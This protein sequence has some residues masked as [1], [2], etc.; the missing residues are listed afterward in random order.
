MSHSTISEPDVAALGVLSI[1]PATQTPRGSFTDLYFTLKYT[2]PAHI[3]AN[4]KALLEPE[5]CWN[6]LSPLTDMLSKLRTD[7]HHL[8]SPTEGRSEPMDSVAWL[9]Q[10]RKRSS[11]VGR[12]TL[13]DGRTHGQVRWALY[14]DKPSFDAVRGHIIPR[15]YGIQSNKAYFAITVDGNCD[16]LHSTS[17][18]LVKR[19]QEDFYETALSQLFPNIDLSD[20]SPETRRATLQNRIGSFSQLMLD[21]GGTREFIDHCYEGRTA[22]ERDQRITHLVNVIVSSLGPCLYSA[23]SIE[24]LR[25]FA[26]GVCL[27]W[28]PTNGQRNMWMDLVAD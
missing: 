4:S 16:G 22:A 18:L 6:M 2:L 20:L 24:A 25:D 26:F 23:A 3:F 27:T 11:D 15:L 1:L 5:D 9:R 17:R 13:L 12:D 19:D 21:A 7:W 8:K 28:S 10:L 14:E